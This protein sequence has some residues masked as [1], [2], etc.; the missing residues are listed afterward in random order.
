MPGPGLTL[1]HSLAPRAHIHSIPHMWRKGRRLAWPG[2]AT[3][4]DVQGHP[5]PHTPLLYP[6]HR[7]E[8]K[9]CF[10]SL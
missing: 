1:R 8:M 9:K 5:L 3:Q 2:Q 7:K 4:Q 10:S 6:N